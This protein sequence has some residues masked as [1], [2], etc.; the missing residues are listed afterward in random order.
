MSISSIEI[1]ELKIGNQAKASRSAW[2]VTRDT[3]WRGE[4]ELRC[5]IIIKFKRTTYET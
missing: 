3:G 5:H 2:A 4:D 1:R